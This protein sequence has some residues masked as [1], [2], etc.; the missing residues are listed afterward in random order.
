MSKKKHQ[1]KKGFL[2]TNCVAVDNRKARHDFSIE[3]DYEA[4]IV[5]IGTEVKSLRTGKANLADSYAEI[6]K[7]GAIWLLNAYIP[8]YE[9]AMKG[10]SHAP[11]RPRKLLLH[12]REIKRL[13]GKVQSKGYTL[14]PLNIH[15]NERGIAKVKLGLAKGKTLYDKRRA[16]KDKEWKRQK[17]DLMG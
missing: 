11:R 4:G 8:E 2:T 13:M 16:E 10:Q 5:L 7:D 14:I 1:K 6:G 9:K 17:K 12:A 3:E 15:F